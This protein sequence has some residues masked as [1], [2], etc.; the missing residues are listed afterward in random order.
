M[1]R[2]PDFPDAVRTRQTDIPLGGSFALVAD[3]L[4]DRKVCDLGCNQGHYL[5]YCGPGSLGLDVAAESVSA[6]QARGLSAQRHDLNILPLPI[7]DEAFEVV[8][9]SHVLEHVQAPLAMLRECNRIVQ[10]EG[11]LVVGLPIEDGLY[12]RLRMDYFG[13]GE[14]H[15]YSFSLPNL[16]KLLR[17]CGFVRERVV[18]HLPRLGNRPSVWNERLNRLLGTQ[19]YSLSAA[20]WY[21]ARK[22]GHPVA[23]HQ[24]SDYFS[25]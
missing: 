21:V 15:L 14:G 18:C 9:L 3:E 13:G 24:L 17:L 22:V 6:C 4:R 7:S 1:A 5:Q 10:L 2:S 19:L 20:Y 25:R 11:K 23:D 8:L 16:D 12:S